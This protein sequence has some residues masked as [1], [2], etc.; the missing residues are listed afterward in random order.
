MNTELRCESET[1]LW[2]PRQPAKPYLRTEGPSTFTIGLC[3]TCQ[4]TLNRQGTKLQPIINKE[5]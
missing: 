1:H 2:T 5:V 3:H 4:A